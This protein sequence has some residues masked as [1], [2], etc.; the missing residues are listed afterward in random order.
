MKILNFNEFQLYYLYNK[1]EYFISIFNL[2]SILK[3]IYN[4]FKMFNNINIYLI[5][6]LY[7]PYNKQLI[8]NY[9]KSISIALL[10]WKERYSFYFIKVLFLFRRILFYFVSR[11]QCMGGRRGIDWASRWIGNSNATLLDIWVIDRLFPS[12]LNSLTYQAIYARL[13][14]MVQIDN[15]IFL[16]IELYF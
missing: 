1:K 7:Q 6:I 3:S 9:R 10:Y 14:N 5:S 4:I 13:I 15:L 12:K 8:F 16:R 2:K 11:I